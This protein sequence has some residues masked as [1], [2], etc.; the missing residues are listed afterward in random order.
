M[1]HHH[2]DQVSSQSLA[3]LA[4]ERG[5]AVAV[6]P[7][8]E[9][10]VQTRGRSWKR[11]LPYFFLALGLFSLSTM[12]LGVDSLADDGWSWSDAVQLALMALLVVG[13]ASQVRGML[14]PTPLGRWLSRPGRPAAK[15]PAHHFV[16]DAV[17]AEYLAAV[18]PAPSVRMKRLLV[19]RNRGGRWFERA[20]VVGVVVLATLAF[21]AML[22]VLGW[23]AYAAG[24]D[25]ASLWLTAPFTALS[26]FALW[27]LFGSARRMSFRGRPFALVSRTFRDSMRLWGS[28]S[29]ATKAALTTTAAASVA[30]AAVVP[31]VVQRDTQLDMFVRDASTGI[32]YRIDLAADASFRSAAPAIAGLEPIAFTTN[33]APVPLSNN[34]TLPRASLL[35]VLEDERGT[36]GIAAFAPGSRQPI[37]VAR[38]APPIPNA[39]FSGGD[40]RLYAVQPDGA[41]WQVDMRTGAATRVG[42]L[43]VPVGPFTFEAESKTLAMVSGATVVRLEPSSG[44]LL[45]TNPSAVPAEEVCAIAD[46]PGGLLFVSRR[47]APEITA[48]HTKT[49]KVEAIRPTGDAPLE[50]CELAVAARK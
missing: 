29:V 37:E 35:V 33:A 23:V 7:A 21:V 39:E 27:Q 11:W 40:G 45:T 38:I 6:T 3:R 34:R 16:L 14:R 12:A 26:G 2:L 1:E 9:E 17:T 10:A 18:G 43:S 4:A 24:W 36:Q 48:L 13:V 30:G 49:R 46:G 31:I 19:L 32:V 44:A 25:D 50:P 47:G 22:A 8:G 15:T 5:L 20:S 28:G 42:Q 41:F